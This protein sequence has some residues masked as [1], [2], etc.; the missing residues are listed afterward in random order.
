MLLIVCALPAELRY[1]DAPAGVTI[2]AG[3]VGPVESAI[4]VARALALARTPY[5]AVI[6]AGIAG[7]YR[8]RARVG[9]ARIV[10]HDALAD[11][12][13]EGGGALALPAGT[14]VETAEADPA[15]VARLAGI[16]THARGLTVSTVTATDATG[17]RLHVR[18][19][20]DVE[21]MEGFAVLRAAAL[22]GTPA[23]GVRG[24][25]NYIGDRTAS[26]WDFAAG[27][28]ATATAL[29]AIVARLASAR[30]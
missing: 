20:H 21:T 29:E 27:A 5:D 1:Y 19:G 18:Y 26:E 2:I 17:V 23:V 7:A 14:L 25:S 28:R 24:I 13:L 22:A 3:G 6:H 15:L 9:D 8:D 12:G 10:T 4:A 11:F 30:V 16:L